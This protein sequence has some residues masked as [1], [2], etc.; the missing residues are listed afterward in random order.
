M[1][2]IVILLLTLCL[3]L[4]G[5]AAQQ[6]QTPTTDTPPVADDPVNED[7]P[8]DD[9]VDDPTD[10]PVDTPPPV[11]YRHPLTGAPLDA[12]WAGTPVAVVINNLKQAL[13]HS[14]VSFADM[15]YEVETEGGITRMLAIY[16]DLTQVGNIGPVR[17]ARSFFNSI[18]V[19]YD[20]PI[21]HC[22]GSKGG[23]NGWYDDTGVKISDW[24]H[25]DAAYYENKYFYRDKDRY[26]YQGYN[27]EHTLFT[28]GQ[29]LT[30]G[31][32]DKEYLAQ[33]ER[34]YGLQFSEEPTLSGAA[35]NSI[36]VHFRG[37][38][39]TIFTYDSGSY[40]TAQYGEDYVDTT[41]G[42]IV[43]FENVI[44]LYTPQWQKDDGN[45]YR[46]YYKLIGEG[47]GMLAIGGKIVPI[48]W[49]RASLNE[50]FSYTLADGTP[51]TLA[52]GH[53]YVAVSST[54]STPVEY[55]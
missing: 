2:R 35:A 6:T 7:P 4:G 44:V 18:A 11:L 33:E 5:C 52:Q 25:L 53:T 12:P 3:L 30:K 45:Y 47:D 37:G 41:T 51:V 10:D 1:K 42:Q 15:I 16:T 43:R 31:L 40:K 28:S 26:N 49:S 9:P 22:G 38:K 19:S 46:S 29:L 48:K 27:W 54:K 17:S 55:Q 24:Q 39:K 50:P 34:D 21:V 20:A 14:G 13:P 36:T 23:R 8:T 32:T